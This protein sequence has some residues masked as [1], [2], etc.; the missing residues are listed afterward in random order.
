MKSKLIILFFILNILL[1]GCAK[2]NNLYLSIFTSEN[3]NNSLKTPI[4]LYCYDIRSKKSEKITSVSTLPTPCLLSYSK[5]DNTIYYTVYLNDSASGEIS[6]LHSLNLNTMETKQ[7]TENLCI[8]DYIINAKDDI[9]LLSVYDNFLTKPVIYHKNTGETENP[10]KDSS[11][12]FTYMSYDVI[13]EHLYLSA[14]NFHKSVKASEDYNSKKS[15][16]PYPDNHIYEYNSEYKTFMPISVSSKMKITNVYAVPGCDKVYYSQKD[17][18]NAFASLCDLNTK[19]TKYIPDIPNPYPELLSST[20][21]I[22]F[23]NEEEVLLIGENSSNLKEYPH[24]IYLYNFKTKKIKLLFTAENQ[25]ILS[26]HLS[27]E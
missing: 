10:L 17:E 18:I 5:S 7:L 15:L 2:S 4:S 23:L 1:S 6:N 27:S 8:T 19:T 24:G 26:F 13:N 14:F 22:C 3:S 21:D 16:S 11:E 12:N 20:N 9:Y 25:K